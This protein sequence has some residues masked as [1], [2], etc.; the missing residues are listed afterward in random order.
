VK[1]GYSIEDFE[2]RSY[3]A[4]KWNRGCWI[5]MQ[6]SGLQGKV[7]DLK[8]RYKCNVVDALT[9]FGRVQLNPE[10]TKSMR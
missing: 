3:L 6:G 1:R 9:R 2:E 10:A 4:G 8:M 5:K 7:G